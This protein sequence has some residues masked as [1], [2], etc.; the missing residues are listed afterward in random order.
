M[1]HGARAPVKQNTCVPAVTTALW[2]VSATGAVTPRTP[3]RTR[4]AH[5]ALCGDMS[6]TSQPT[7][8]GHSA[9]GRT[10]APNSCAPLS[11]PLLP[12]GPA[13]SLLPP[14]SASARRSSEWDL[15]ARSFRGG[16]ISGT[17]TWDRSP[18]A[19]PVLCPPFPGEQAAPCG[20]VHVP[21]EALGL[22]PVPPS[23]LR[24]L[25]GQFPSL[26]VVG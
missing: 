4:A 2:P 15:A 26:R 7:L 1:G 22:S 5:G 19:L 24:S 8:P 25:C 14:T 9:S 10:A 12:R 21:A 23:A 6:H 11:R 20:R 17:M 13:A 16:L 3:Q 18:H